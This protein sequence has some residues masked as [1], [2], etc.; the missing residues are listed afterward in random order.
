[1]SV[2]T[3]G[4]TRACTLARFHGPHKPSC[5]VLRPAQL[6]QQKADN[7]LLPNQIVLFAADNFRNEPDTAE[8]LSIVSKIAVLLDNHQNAVFWLN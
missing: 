1:M 4:L 2:A 5:I 3:S 6:N 8:F 7:L